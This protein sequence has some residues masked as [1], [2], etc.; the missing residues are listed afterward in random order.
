MERPKKKLYFIYN[1]HA[2]KEHIKG[3]L[4][5]IL[6]VMADAGY[7]LTVY[8]TKGARDAMEQ[9]EQLPEVYDLVVCS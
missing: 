4:Y 1:P 2:G 6:K 5:G 7:E 9:I 8:P 3:K